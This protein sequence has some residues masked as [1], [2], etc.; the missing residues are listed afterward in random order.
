MPPGR[1]RF[2]FARRSHR[3]TDVSSIG[4]RRRTGDCGDAKADCAEQ[5]GDRAEPA[6]A[7][8]TA[9]RGGE[10]VMSIDVE[11]AIKKDIRNNPVVREI[12]SAQKRE[13]LRTLTNAGLIVAMLLF[14]AF[15]HFKITKNNYVISQLEQ[16]RT[17][18]KAYNR[19]LRLE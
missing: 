17:E 10:A 11:Y 15:Q 1:R 9:S 19:Q 8:R 3:Q 13:F 16:Q 6:G 2:S 4:A 5:R 7:K 14:A 18:E 12:D